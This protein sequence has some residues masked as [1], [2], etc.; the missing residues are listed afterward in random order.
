MQ[1][2]LWWMGW[3]IK[4]HSFRHGQINECR[5]LWLNDLSVILPGT[6]TLTQCLKWCKMNL[7]GSMFPNAWLKAFLSFLNTT[8]SNAGTAGF[9]CCQSTA[10][11][12]TSRG[13]WGK[14]LGVEWFCDRKC[15][16]LELK[17][18]PQMYTRTSTFLSWMENGDVGCC[19]PWWSPRI[20]K[21][22]SCCF[23]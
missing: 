11:R 3:G 7:S 12:R 14:G 9:E 15:L 20:K 10:T 16:V 1:A 23:D 19:F 18:L 5:G 8:N 17:Y 2:I 21:L 6:Q 4:L 22:D 13:C